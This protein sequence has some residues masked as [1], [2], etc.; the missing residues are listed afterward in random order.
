[1]GYAIPLRAGDVLCSPGRVAD[2]LQRNYVS[3]DR[4]QVNRSTR[5]CVCVVWQVQDVIDSWSICSAVLCVESL[6]F[7]MGKEDAKRKMAFLLVNCHL[8]QPRLMCNAKLF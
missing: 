4:V 1:L 2:S 5:F 3:S 7:A 8:C 6:L